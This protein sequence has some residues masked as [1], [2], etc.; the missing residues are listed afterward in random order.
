MIP[1]DAR[2][3]QLFLSKASSPSIICAEVYIVGNSD[4]VICT[5]PGFT[6]R[7]SCKH[8][9][10]VRQIMKDNDGWYPVKLDIDSL[11]ESD[12]IPS[13]TKEFNEFMRTH[14]KVEIL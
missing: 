7:S 9:D 11:S 10:H 6:A 2:L 14:G 1:S 4:N 3:I 5:C 12:G 8:V 13:S